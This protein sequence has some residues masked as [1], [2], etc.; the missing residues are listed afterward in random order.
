MFFLGSAEAR[1]DLTPLINTPSANA[2][3]GGD[4][5]VVIQEPANK[6]P[7]STPW[8]IDS[9]ATYQFTNNAAAILIP[10]PSSL[11]ARVENG[12]VLQDTSKGS[13]FLKIITNG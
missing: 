6:C 13:A 12:S 3:I 9:G 7:A 8:L 4:A 11:R 5:C 2:S 10:S 1:D